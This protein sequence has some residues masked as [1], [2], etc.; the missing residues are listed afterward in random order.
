M[1]KNLSHLPTIR[2]LSVLLHQFALPRKSPSSKSPS[3]ILQKMSTSSSIAPP[4]LLSD[5][6]PGASSSSSYLTTATEVEELADTLLQKATIEPPP[7][8]PS[9]RY[10]DV[11]SSYHFPDCSFVYYP[12]L[13]IESTIFVRSEQTSQ[14]RP[15]Q[16]SIMAKN[17][18]TLTSLTSSAAR[19]PSTVLK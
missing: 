8:K 12:K 16:E 13:I 7:P 15:F 1:H 14:T 9:P 2:L 17:T 5:L 4:Q 19:A 11:C 3:S 18:T 10:A 6:A